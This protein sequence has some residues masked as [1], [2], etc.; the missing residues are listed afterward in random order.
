MSELSAAVDRVDETLATVEHVVGQLR[1]HLDNV[2]AAEADGQRWVVKDNAAWARET[3]ARLLKA[4]ALAYTASVT[5]EDRGLYHA[6]D[7][8]GAATPGG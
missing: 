2:A 5:L 4:A 7:G 8:A 3:A 1:R 6:V